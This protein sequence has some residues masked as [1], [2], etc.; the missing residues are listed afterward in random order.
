MAQA[1]VCATTLVEVPLLSAPSARRISGRWISHDDGASGHAQC[2]TSA[3]DQR[4]KHVPWQWGKA[5]PGKK[6][7]AHKAATTGVKG[8]LHCSVHG[9]WPLGCWVV[10]IT[11]GVGACA[12]QQRIAADGLDHGEFECS[13]LLAHG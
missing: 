4:R 3:Y 2:S 9:I 1:G 7:Q 8:M 13:C 12:T 10:C 5:T 11:L 6:L